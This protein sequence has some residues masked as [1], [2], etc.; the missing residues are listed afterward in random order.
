MKLITVLLACI[1]A[2]TTHAQTSVASKAKSAIDGKNSGLVWHTPIPEMEPP[3]AERSTIYVTFRD[4]SGGEGVAL[5]PVI[6]ERLKKS[7]YT[8]ETNPDKAQY[9]LQVTLR[10]FGENPR[11]DRGRA[12]AERLGDIAGASGEAINNVASGTGS[13]PGSIVG[14]G[15]GEVKRLLTTKHEWNMTLDLVIAER[16]AEGV[17][18]TV[19][20]GQ[21][22]GQTEVHV[23]DNS[24]ASQTDTSTREQTMKAK[25]SHLIHGARITAWAQGRKLS[26]D[27]AQEALVP[28][29]LN[30]IANAVPP[31]G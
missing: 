6:R 5:Q 22:R 28:K 16:V 31:V 30:A 12:Q 29:L 27:E 15:V 14:L 11:S 26:Q 21:N 1:F 4:A 10:F 7:G 25:K 3:S 24:L 9:R 13:I 18:T 17:D 23:G 2:V 19:G 20:T 8:I